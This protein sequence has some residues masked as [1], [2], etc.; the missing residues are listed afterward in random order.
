MI[1]VELFGLYR[2]KYQMKDVRL[3]A[4]SVKELFE[5]LYELNPA[6]TV[7]ELR[8]SIVIVNDVN[9]NDLKKYRTKLK[10]GDHVLIMSPASGG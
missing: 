9:F 8:N 3:E 10:D 2:L 5:K 6:Y 7:K 4:S 1:T